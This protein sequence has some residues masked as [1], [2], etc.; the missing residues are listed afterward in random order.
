MWPG[1]A[2]DI[3]TPLSVDRPTSEALSQAYASINDSHGHWGSGLNVKQWM[4]SEEFGYDELGN[5]ASI[6]NGWGEVEYRYD[7]ANRMLEAGKR[8]YSF[9]ANGNLVG[10]ALGGKEAVYSYTVDNR[11]AHAV[12]NL[13]DSYSGGMGNFPPFES[14]SPLWSGTIEV[15][16]TYDALGRR[17]AMVSGYAEEE[18]PRSP[19]QIMAEKCLT[20]G[21]NGFGWEATQT[22]KY[23]YDGLGFTVMAEIVSTESAHKD[24]RFGWKP[25]QS[26]VEYIHANGA[27]VERREL[28]GWHN[29]NDID[30][31]TQDIL[32]S[33]MQ[34]TDAWGAV[35][36]S[37]A[38]DAFGTAYRGDLSGTNAV[39]YN[40]KRYDPVLSLYDYGFR[41]YSPRVARWTTQDPIRAGSNWYVFCIN[42]P[43]NFID[44]DGLYP[45]ESETYPPSNYP[46]EGVNSGYLMLATPA[47]KANVH[48]DQMASYA[49]YERGL[50]PRTDQD[51]SINFDR[52][53]IPTIF[54]QFENSSMYD[55]ALEDTEGFVFNNLNPET[56]DPRHLQY[57]ESEGGMVTIWETNGMV[58][59][60]PVPTTY[61]DSELPEAYAGATWVPLNQREDQNLKN[62]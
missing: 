34:V 49:A 2:T 1:N 60:P 17:N 22:Q 57:Y 56:G 18:S 30:Y 27:Q 8:G 23:L 36:E 38:Y 15:S 11:L 61:P 59:D 33:T 12:T 37:Y 39:G 42:A 53:S 52:D 46:G 14:K 21:G 13:V 31:Y 19:K 45:Y 35:K 3:S 44:L 7:A 43:M 47:T 55:V 4:W 40:G 41:D 50:D 25:G 20:G 54:G 58:P 24:N 16:C 62:E 48:C 6:T 10:E 28:S 9:D 29:G 32:G 5:R 26:A 51:Y